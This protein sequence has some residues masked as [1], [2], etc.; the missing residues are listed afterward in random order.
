[1]ERSVEWYMSE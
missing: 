1:M